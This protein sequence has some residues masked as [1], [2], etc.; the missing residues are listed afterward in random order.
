MEGGPKNTDDGYNYTYENKR[1]NKGN[2]G[3][4]KGGKN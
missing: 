1:G 4:K 3:N 2:K